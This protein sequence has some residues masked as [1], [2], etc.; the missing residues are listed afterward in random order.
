VFQ[1]D[2]YLTAPGAASAA[3]VVSA[4]GTVRTLTFDKPDKL[5]FRNRVNTKSTLETRY[6]DGS[7]R[8][9]INCATDG[10]RN[11]T[12]SLL[13]GVYRPERDERVGVV[14]SGGNTT[15][16]EFER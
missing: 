14:I 9:A 10:A 7:F 11:V 1:A 16:V 8:F 4:E 5:E 12:L 3:T 13:G 2:V 6:P 15:A